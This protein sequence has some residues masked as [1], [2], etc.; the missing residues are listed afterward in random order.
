[1]PDGSSFKTN[2]TLWKK[3]IGFHVVK[4]IIDKRKWKGFFCG[5]QVVLLSG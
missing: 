4:E 1:M 5:L 3:L 2:D